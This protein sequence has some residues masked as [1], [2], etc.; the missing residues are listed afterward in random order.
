M[1]VV[2]YLLKYTVGQVF[3][4]ASLYYHPGVRSNDL[5]GFRPPQSFSAGSDTAFG[6]RGR[7]RLEC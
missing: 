6:S 2:D 3:G 4:A 1:T 7:C 5:L